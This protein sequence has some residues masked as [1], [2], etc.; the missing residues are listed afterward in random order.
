VAVRTSTRHRSGSTR[1]APPKEQQGRPA[2]LAFGPDHPLARASELVRT[3]EKQV[4]VTLAAIAP[5]LA[6]TL[7]D[8]PI[9]PTLL[10]ASLA[11]ELVLVV[12]LLLARQVRAERAWEVIIDGS[13]ALDADEVMQERRRLSNPK[14]REQL[15]RSL[16]RALDA[17][18]HWHQILVASRPPEGVR[19]L[20]RFAPEI[21]QIVTQLRDEPADVRGIALLARY[22]A[23]GP[24]SPLYSGDAEALRRELARIAHLLGCPPRRPHE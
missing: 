24:G 8:A 13:E 19:L 6:E 2:S 22:L 11:V 17:A 21:R 20:S 1:P 3:L 4:G 5:A 15:S 7:L 23:G 14:R 10:S 12:A 16:G 18:E 9:A